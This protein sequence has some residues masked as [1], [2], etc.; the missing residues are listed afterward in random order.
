ML[1]HVLQEPILSTRSLGTFTLYKKTFL[2]K[3]LT[4]VRCIKVHL[5]LEVALLDGSIC[6]YLAVKLIAVLLLRRKEDR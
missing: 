6:G 1:L 2:T 3:Q 5:K 4:S